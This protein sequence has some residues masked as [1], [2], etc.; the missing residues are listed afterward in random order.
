[1]LMNSE[2]GELH[3]AAAGNRAGVSGDDDLF[4]LCPKKF[5]V[6]LKQ[7][8]E[9]DIELFQ[10]SMASD[11]IDIWQESLFYRGCIMVYVFCGPCNQAAQT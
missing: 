6:T 4:F 8:S 11:M 9:N 1:M 2:S 3:G 5:Y 7:L 10:E